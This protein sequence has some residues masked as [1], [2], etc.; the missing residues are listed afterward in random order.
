MSRKL[1]SKFD[2][3]EYFEVMQDD[4]SD[5]EL[6]SLINDA[7]LS[8]ELVKRGYLFNDEIVEWYE[9]SE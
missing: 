5:E 6:D 4:I 8:G 9:I 3:M 7:V 2:L 1:I